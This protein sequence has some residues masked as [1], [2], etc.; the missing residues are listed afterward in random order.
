ME[1]LTDQQLVFMSDEMYLPIHYKS[2]VV[3]PPYFKG[4]GVHSVKE[5][6]D[7]CEQ[8]TEYCHQQAIIKQNCIKHL[9]ELKFGIEIENS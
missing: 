1:K 7:I 9:V 5:L 3:R 6:E 4:K 8:F 2:M